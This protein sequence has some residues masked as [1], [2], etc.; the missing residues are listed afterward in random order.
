[1]IHGLSLSCNI[2]AACY[3]HDMR[4]VL[5]DSKEQ[6]EKRFDEQVA[7]KNELQKQVSEIDI[8]LV[9]LQGEYR[10]YDALLVNYTDDTTSSPVEGEVIDANTITVEEPK[11]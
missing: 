5:L 1:M 7:K 10:A 4:Q 9:K 8:E 11:E 3:N 2:Y 6:T